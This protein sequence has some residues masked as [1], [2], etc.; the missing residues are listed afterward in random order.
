A[1]RSTAVWG[2]A[3]AWFYWAPPAS[4]RP[5]RGVTPRQSACIRSSSWNSATRDGTA[6]TGA[7]R[8]RTL[9]PLE[10][11]FALVEE[12]AHAL[13]L[14]ARREQLHER[15]PLDR[16]A[17]LEGAIERRQR[18]LGSGVGQRWT[19]RELRRVLD[20]KGVDI[21]FGD[22]VHQADLER[23]RRV[24][25]P[26]RVHDIPRLRRAPPPAPPPPR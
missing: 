21:P 3:G 15:L 17:L 16:Q 1:A 24:H 23:L 6:S 13:L 10:L 8:T 12:G 4:K 19:L 26:P 9:P 18:A 11:R 2:P 14:V 5:G 7:C 22:A 25:A 20:G